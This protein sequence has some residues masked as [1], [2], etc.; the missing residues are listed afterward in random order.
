MLRHVLR[1][2]GRWRSRSIEDY[3]DAALTEDICVKDLGEGGLGPKTR[4]ERQDILDMKGGLLGIKRML[5][6]YLT[7]PTGAAPARQKKRKIW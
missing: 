4:A 5:G 2:L 1:A 3:M 6:S 7:T